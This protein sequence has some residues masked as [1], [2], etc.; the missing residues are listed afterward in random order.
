VL[1]HGQGRGDG[2]VEVVFEMVGGPPNLPAGASSSS[3]A[4][5]AGAGAGAGAGQALDP[6]VFSFAFTTQETL[7]Q[8]AE[9]YKERLMAVNAIVDEYNGKKGDIEDELTRLREK[10]KRLLSKVGGFIFTVNT[11]RSV[12]VAAGLTLS[13]RFLSLSLCRDRAFAPP[14]CRHESCRPG[15]VCAC[16]PKPRKRTA[17]RTSTRRSSRVWT[18]CWPASRRSCKTCNAAGRR[19]AEPYLTHIY[20]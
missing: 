11:Y 13:S 5:G 8:Q 15:R 2:L 9:E 20:I 16:K 14:C 18:H 10:H 1:A 17:N 3:S 19:S 6:L 4:T 7:L 12:V